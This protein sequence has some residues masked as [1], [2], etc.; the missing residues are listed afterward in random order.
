MALREGEDAELKSLPAEGEGEEEGG[1]RHEGGKTRSKCK[2]GDT[3][4]YVIG[5]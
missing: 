4:R 2:G 1:R 3:S 5:S